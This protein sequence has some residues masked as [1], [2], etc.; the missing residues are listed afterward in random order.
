MQYKRLFD[1][2]HYQL[3]TFPREDALVSKVNGEW[4]KTSTQSFVEQA[5][6]VS[7]GLLRLGVQKND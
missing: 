5:N 1:F 2:P 4:I 3:E 7:R 6:A